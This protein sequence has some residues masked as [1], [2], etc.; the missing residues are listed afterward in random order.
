MA[1]ASTGAMEMAPRAAYSR[2]MATEPSRHERE[3]ARR[4]EALANLEQLRHEGDSLLGSALVRA[5]HRAADHFAA[6]DAATDGAADP[7]EV[8][9]RR[10]G[11][12]LSV[13]AFVG[14][15][16]YLWATYLR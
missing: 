10:I 4:R 14:L 9:G 11:R 8:W 16:I 12:A 15:C 6:R 7:A 3:E 1:P 13:A 2:P 5:G